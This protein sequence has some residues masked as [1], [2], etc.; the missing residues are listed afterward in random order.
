MC[1]AV[2]QENRCRYLRFILRLNDCIKWSY[3]TLLC[4]H[5]V[6][7]LCEVASSGVAAPSLKEDKRGESSM[8]RSLVS[9][10]LSSVWLNTPCQKK[11]NRGIYNGKEKYTLLCTLCLCFWMSIMLMGPMHCSE[12][13]HCLGWNATGRDRHFTHPLKNMFFT[14]ARP[15]KKIQPWVKMSPSF[16]VKQRK[17]R[18]SGGDEPFGC[19]KCTSTTLKWVRQS[20]RVAAG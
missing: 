10:E 1:H 2:R 4:M 13:H 12:L 14:C 8:P 20:L 16:E 7:Y 11:T 3:L 5:G 6:M 17:K 19:S 15:W 18:L 9:W